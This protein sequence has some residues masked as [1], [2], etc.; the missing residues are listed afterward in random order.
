M[1]SCAS[2]IVIGNPHT[3]P[4]SDTEGASQALPHTVMHVYFMLL[5]L[6]LVMFL[7]TVDDL[8]PLLPPELSVL[9]SDIPSSLG[10]L[11]GDYR[12]PLR[13]AILLSFCSFC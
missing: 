13:L 7:I 4:E 3:A 11:G 2:G 10:M 8:L 9:S 6:F 5:T 12:F 1:F